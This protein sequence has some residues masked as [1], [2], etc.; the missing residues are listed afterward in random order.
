MIRTR[1]FIRSAIH[2]TAVGGVLVAATAC[3]SDEP[4]TATDAATTESAS[5]ESAAT[6]PTVTEPAITEPATTNAPPATDLA[7]TEPA[8]TAAPATEPQPEP[9]PECPEPV[10]NEATQSAG[11][12]AAF[13]PALGEYAEGVT[14]DQSGNVFVSLIDNGQLLKFAPGSSE[15]EVFAEVP[16][17]DGSGTGFLGLAVDDIGHVYGASESGVWK[18][19]CRT[20]EPT[21]FEGTEDIGFPNAL[22]F[23]DQ[24]NLFLS[25][26]WSNGNRDT[27]FGAI[28]RI[29]PSGSVE[30]WLES[31][32]LGGTGAFGLPEPGGINGIAFRDGTIYA[33]VVERMSIVSI[34][35]L[36]DGSPGEITTIVEGGII[37][38]GMALDEQGRIYIADVG[39]SAVKRVNADG[40]IE[41]LA[42]GAAAGLDLNTS[43]AFGIG[44]TE[45]TLYTVDLANIPDFSTGAGPALV[46]IDVDTAGQL[47]PR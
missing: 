36:E 39:N 10:P 32:A 11:V 22:A 3:A 4:S 20:G 40:T 2:A 38:D 7:A 19:D 45:L 5:T 12:V 34:P 23:D 29:D 27:P 9:E 35:V 1:T 18:F 28:W 37:P 26:T 47:P 30:K 14:V 24:G 41:V 46:A 17:W 33:N 16:D 25:D 44:G 15:Y 31:E 21:V 6:E 13:D 42:E 8:A 43:V